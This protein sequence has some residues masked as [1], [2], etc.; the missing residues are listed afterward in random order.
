MMPRS[1]MLVGWFIWLIFRTLSYRIF[2]V[3]VIKL[4]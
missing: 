1:Y 3:L 2:P 4:F